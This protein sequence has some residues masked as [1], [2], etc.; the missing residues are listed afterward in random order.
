MHKPG[1][2]NNTKTILQT[3]GVWTVCKGMNARWSCYPGNV[4]FTLEQKTLI[5][6]DPWSLHLKYS[7]WSQPMTVFI[8]QLRIR[9]EILN[10]STMKNIYFL[11]LAYNV[12]K[13]AKFLFT[14]KGYWGNKQ[15]RFAF[16]HVRLLVLTKHKCY[17]LNITCHLVHSFVVSICY[18]ENESFNL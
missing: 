8:Y 4:Y 11:E 17:D 2:N 12:Y 9:E 13:K 1:K 14:I 18:Q 10:I 16:I 6:F 7:L 5:L 15:N 3:T